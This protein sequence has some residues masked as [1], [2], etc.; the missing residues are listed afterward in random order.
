MSGEAAM[1]ELKVSVQCVETK[2][3]SEPAAPRVRTRLCAPGDH[4]GKAISYLT[5]ICRSVLFR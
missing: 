1:S 2:A 5:L 3:L 4:A